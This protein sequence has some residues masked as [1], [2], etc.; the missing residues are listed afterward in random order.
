MQAPCVLGMHAPLLRKHGCGVCGVGLSVLNHISQALRNH[1]VGVLGI[2]LILLCLG[3]LLCE[4]SKQFLH[5]FHNASRLKLVSVRLR[6]L[7]C[8]KVTIG[9]H[10]QERSQSAS[11]G[12]RQHGM[13]RELLQQNGPGCLP[14]VIFLLQS[15]NRTLQSINS[16][17]KIFHLRCVGLVVLLPLDLCSLQI[18]L[19]CC[20]CGLQVADL[21]HQ[22]LD[23]RLVLSQVCGQHL[24]Q[25]STLRDFLG[26]ASSGVCAELIE[27]RKRDCLCILL[28]LRLDRHIPEQLHDLLDGRH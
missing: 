22:R 5:E 25:L 9:A 27:L 15:K 18:S 24:N 20:D 21:S 3:T 16:F 12:V 1:L 11:C 17:G 6:T 28:R 26:L 10:L 13:L 8:E 14:V 23:V 2:H 19:A 4:F 7:A